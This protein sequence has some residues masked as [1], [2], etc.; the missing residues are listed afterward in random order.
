[1]LHLG[2]PN[3]S[4]AYVRPPPINER[5]IT[6]L[7]P[8]V[9]V[10]PLIHTARAMATDYKSAW[11]L[12]PEPRPRAAAWALSNGQV[13]S[14]DNL[15]TAGLAPL[16]EGPTKCARGPRAVATD[17][18]SSGSRQ[19]RWA[20]DLHALQDPDFERRSGASRKRRHPGEAAP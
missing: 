17:C 15:R 3:D 13:V 7:L 9:V 1:L 5:L 11:D 12:L 18:A 10:P 6:N 8:L 16:F 2:Q 19:V 14:F 20:I 4:G